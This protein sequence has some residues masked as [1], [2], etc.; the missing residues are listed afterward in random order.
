MRDYLDINLLGWRDEQDLD[1]KAMNN[2]VNIVSRANERV[3][4]GLKLLPRE[5]DKKNRVTQ[6]LEQ[7][8]KDTTKLCDWKK[9]LK[10]QGFSK[11]SDEVKN[12]LDINLLGWRD[13]L[14]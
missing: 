5:L 14:E 12:Y 10:G 1:G 2:A 3:E 7:E 11:C 13:E 6:E 9:A 4:H 8:Y